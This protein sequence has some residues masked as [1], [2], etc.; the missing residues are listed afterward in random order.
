MQRFPQMVFRDGSALPEHGVDFLIVE[1]EADLA[2]ALGDGWREG[3][4]AQQAAPR[5]PL[6][7]DGDG[8]K[9]GSLPKAKRARKPRA[10]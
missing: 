3:L 2:A 7:H 5:H 4:E 1:C 8:A 6:D 10:A 9:G